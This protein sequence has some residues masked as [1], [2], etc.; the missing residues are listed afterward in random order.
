MVQPRPGGRPAIYSRRRVAVAILCLSRTGC[1][2]RQ[3]PHHFP[4]WEM[5]CWYFKIWNEGGGRIRRGQRAGPR[6]WRRIL[7]HARLAMHSTATTSVGPRI[8]EP[9]SGGDDRT[10]GAPV[11]APPRG[12]PPRQPVP[13]AR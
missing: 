8:P 3:L 2:C 9:W 11:I 1:S 10:H 6:R 4:P 12:R 5:V 7:D 13:A